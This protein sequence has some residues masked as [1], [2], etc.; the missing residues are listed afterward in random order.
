MVLCRGAWLALTH[1]EL[2]SREV[3]CKEGCSAP[4][5]SSFLAVSLLRAAC[6][7]AWECWVTRL[8]SVSSPIRQAQCRFRQSQMY[9]FLWV[10]EEC[11]C[12]PVLLTEEG[13]EARPGLRSVSAAEK[14]QGH[15]CAARRDQPHTLLLAGRPFCST[16]VQ[17]SS[18][19]HTSGW[20]PLERWWASLTGSHM[21]DQR[22]HKE[23]Y[24]EVSG[25]WEVLAQ[26]HTLVPPL[27]LSYAPPIFPGLC[28]L[29]LPWLCQFFFL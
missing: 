1:K 7:G 26:E 4:E 2:H 27:W 3:L 15:E 25:V 21:Y 19:Q 23:S 9:H 22:M 14:S 29:F 5:S 6:E 10:C 16:V 12:H 11:H 8:C 24:S 13:E 18:C 17:E 28:L 20:W